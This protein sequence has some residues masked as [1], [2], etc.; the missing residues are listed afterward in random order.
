MGL[1]RRI[2]GRRSDAGAHA[3]TDMDNSPRVS[4]SLESTVAT[5]QALSASFR[6]LPDTHPSRGNVV[7]SLTPSRKALENIARNLDLAA[8]AL[9]TGRDF[10]GN[11]MSTSEVGA[12]L[13]QMHATYTDLKDPTAGYVSLLVD[14][15]GERAF[16]EHVTE[17]RELGEALRGTR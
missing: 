6:R 4:A 13:L 1:W 11:P 14:G 2:L 5:I 10:R 16:W 8:D 3:P 12:A 9:R 17:L 15:D 7:G